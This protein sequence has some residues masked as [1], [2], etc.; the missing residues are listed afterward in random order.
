M[1]VD[2]KEPSGRF[3]LLEIEKETHLINFKPFHSKTKIF[4]KENV[5]EKDVYRRK[6]SLF[7]QLK[8]SPT[9]PAFSNQF[10]IGGLYN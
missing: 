5:N 4:E 2:P 9:E 10:P 6:W 8:D 3:D 1:G 7:W